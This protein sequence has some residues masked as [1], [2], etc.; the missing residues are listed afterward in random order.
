MAANASRETAGDGPHRNHSRRLTILFDGANR[1]P[2]YVDDFLIPAD[3]K[4]YTN[5]DKVISSQWSH[6]TA[7][8]TEELHAFAARLG[9]RRD[10]FQP[11]K[12]YPDNEYTRRVCPEKIGTTRPGSRDH[13]DVTARVRAR[14]IRLG[15]IP[16]RFGCEPWRDRKKERSEADEF[17]RRT[18]AEQATGAPTEGRESVP[19]QTGGYEPVNDGSHYGQ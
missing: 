13:Y 11:A 1:V 15:A 2:V 14:A 3:V 19:A 5:G 16:V 10:W 9:M 12:V 7:D 18:E 8:T 4:D 17:D 6:L